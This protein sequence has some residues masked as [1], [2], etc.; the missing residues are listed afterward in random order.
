LSTA[1]TTEVDNVVPPVTVTVTMPSQGAAVAGQLTARSVTAHTVDPLKL[2]DDALT[3]L[4]L[5]GPTAVSQMPLKQTM[6]SLPVT[7]RTVM[8]GPWG[9]ADIVPVVSDQLV[10]FQSS[11]ADPCGEKEHGV[12]VVLL[13]IDHAVVVLTPPASVEELEALIVVLELLDDH[14]DVS[15][16][17]VVKALVSVVPDPA[18]VEDSLLA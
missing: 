11:Q 6:V 2:A 1:G 5:V 18:V 7:G 10:K 16:A 12:L 14:D 9:C 13:V 3:F 4:E 8:L 17:A 15:G